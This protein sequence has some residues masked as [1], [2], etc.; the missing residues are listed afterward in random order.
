VVPVAATADRERH[1]HHQA[2]RRYDGDGTDEQ[3][4]ACEAA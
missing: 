2:S 3:K 4:N 1:R